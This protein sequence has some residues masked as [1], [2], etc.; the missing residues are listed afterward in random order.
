MTNEEA[1]FMLS[2]YR[3]NGADAADAEMASALAQ[4][5]RDPALKKWFENEQAFDQ[6]VADKLGSIAAP[7]GLRESILAGTKM[8]SASAPKPSPKWWL[9]PWSIGLAA[10]AAVVVAFTLTISEPEIRTARLP[11]MDPI[12]K[13]ALADFGGA[14]GMGPKADRLGAFGAWLIDDNSRLGADVMP[15]DLAELEAYGCRTINVAGH[16]VFE[17]CFQRESGWY[18]VF[19]APREAFDSEGL[20]R[21]PMFHEKGEFIAA[22]WADEKFAYLVSGTTDLASLRGLL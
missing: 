18:H 15:V 16:E 5:E 2:G 7:S 21:D 3:P 6:I 11:G 13:V 8:S 20:H 17:I 1:K 10:A 14:H 12:L 4:A 9:Q 19:I 22:S